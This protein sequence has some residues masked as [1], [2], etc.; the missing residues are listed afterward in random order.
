MLLHRWM[1]VFFC[2]NIQYMD[3]PLGLDM[4]LLCSRAALG[5]SCCKGR[6]S[7]GRSSC[8]NPL[9]N[10]KKV[11]CQTDQVGHKRRSHSLQATSSELWMKFLLKTRLIRLEQNP[12]VTF[13][14]FISHIISAVKEK[15]SRSFDTDESC[16]ESKNLCSLKTYDSFYIYIYS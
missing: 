6:L 3:F 1:C 2:L 15:E 8:E 5:S 14:C 7:W 10:N 11:T 16:R 4:L 9:R 12:T 13:S